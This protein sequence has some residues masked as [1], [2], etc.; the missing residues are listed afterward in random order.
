[1]RQ[2]GHT[3]DVQE[4]VQLPAARIPLPRGP[5]AQGI[6]LPGVRQ[7]VLTSRQDEKPH[8]DR[9][10][11]LHAKGHR[12]PTS[13]VPIAA[14]R[15]LATTTTKAFPSIIAGCLRSDSAFTRAHI[16]LLQFIHKYL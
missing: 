9:A 13:A 2:D 12:F 4:Q 14:M 15:R 11:V 16:F 6:P 5:P 8:E 10:R 7:G 1:M 3:E